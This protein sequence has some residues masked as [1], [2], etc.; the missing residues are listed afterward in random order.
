MISSFDDLI[1]T[2]LRVYVDASANIGADV[3]R[4]GRI[5]SPNTTL[6]YFLGV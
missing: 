2:A 3:Y 4:Q 5:K 1:T 6:I